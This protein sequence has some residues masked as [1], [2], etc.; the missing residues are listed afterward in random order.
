MIAALSMVGD[1]L[2][3]LLLGVIGLCVIAYVLTGGADFGGGAWDLLARGPRA[4]QQRDLVEHAIAPIW[5]A[6]HIWMIVI[7]VLVF[8]GF[9]R[10]FAAIAVALHVPIAMA[11]VGIV[12]RGAA[13]SFRGYGLQPD[14][15]R[16]AW[17]RVF[18]WASV[19]TPFCLGLVVAGLSSGAIRVADGRVTTGFFA[20]FTSSFA[21]CVGLFAL[22]LFTLLAAVYLTL[23]A[24]GGSPL[25]EDF[26][27]RAIATELVAGV[28]AALTA[29]RASVDAPALFSGLVSQSWS[30]AVQLLTAS[31]AATTLL[32]LWKRRYTLARLAV[33]T[34][35]GL[36]VLGWGLA[37]DG[38]LLLPDIHVQ[39][40]GLRAD[41]VR[42]VL[43]ILAGGSVVLG[44]ALWLLYRVFK[45]PSR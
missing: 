6:N 45:R 16:A 5:E 26:R 30:I 8:T 14:A 28:M 2:P 1:P 35:V 41:V 15:Q 21:V 4:A 40:A 20:G 33:I 25:Q 7:V 22:A 10:A 9:P 29:W 42:P 17:G 31:A 44:P 37:M 36:V 24:E 38:H 43:W 19:A 34:Q 18:A 27:R 39:T 13:F 3:W 32:A 11:L 23:D 12:L